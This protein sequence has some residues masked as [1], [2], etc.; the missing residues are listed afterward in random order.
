M[1]PLDVIVD[2]SQIYFN[3]AMDIP[4]DGNIFLNETERQ[5]YLNQTQALALAPRLLLHAEML[6]ITHPEYGN[7]MT[8][9]VPAD[10]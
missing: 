7:S 4:D 1:L 6:T 2:F 3:V 9:K 5:K 10:F 8:F